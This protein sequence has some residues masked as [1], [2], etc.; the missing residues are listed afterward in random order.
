MELSL[1]LTRELDVGYT[2]C[3]ISVAATCSNLIG[4]L[5][6]QLQFTV[7]LTMPQ[8]VKIAGIED[9]LVD[10]VLLTRHVLPRDRVREVSKA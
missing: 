3:L 5:I 4:S 2:E 1:E 8:S 6:K 9:K 7:V 10:N